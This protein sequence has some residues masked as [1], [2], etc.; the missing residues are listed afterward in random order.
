MKTKIYRTLVVC[1]LTIVLV[2]LMG[3]CMPRFGIIM[4]CTLGPCDNS[5]VTVNFRAPDFSSSH[6]LFFM[7]PA[8][9]A[10]EVDW[11]ALSG[12][13]SIQS[14]ER[15]DRFHYVAEFSPQ[16][17]LFCDQYRH[18]LGRVVPTASLHVSV[19]MPQLQPGTYRITI[20]TS[21]AP[22]GIFA[23]ISCLTA[24]KLYSRE[25]FGIHPQYVEETHTGN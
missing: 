16:T 11:G 7:L 5:T 24:R 23:E 25:A 20:T 8:S 21:N 12:S 3:T 10:S 1:V 2:F 22:S 14:I 15:P 19:P 4:S 6:H 17:L 18:D 13:Y 9:T